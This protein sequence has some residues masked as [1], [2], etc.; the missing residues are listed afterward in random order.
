MTNLIRLPLRQSSSKAHL[1]VLCESKEPALQSD[2][3]TR[4]AQ[5]ATTTLELFFSGLDTETLKSLLELQHS[6]WARLAALQKSWAA[7]WL[8]W[9]SY[10]DKI[11]SA[12]RMSKLFEMQS[13]MLASAAQLL[14]SQVTGLAALQENI[15]ADYSTLI[16]QILA[17]RQDQ[18]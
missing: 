1:P 4:A 7:E 10:A 18:S 13:N 15:G 8:D 6:A 11:K 17:A 3:A 9:F 14:G 5:S 12:N 2:R 16:S